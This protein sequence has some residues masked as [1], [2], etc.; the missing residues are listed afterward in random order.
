MKP[1]RK[2]IGQ[3]LERSLALHGN[4]PRNEIQSVVDRVWESLPA[5]ES[6]ELGERIEQYPSR[7][8]SRAWRLAA[9]AA[10]LI[11][12]SVSLIRSLQWNYRPP[13]HI[14]TA[15]ALPMETESEVLP[16]PPI[17]APADANVDGLLMDEVSAHISRT[18]PAPMER[19]MTLIPPY[20]DMAQSGGTQ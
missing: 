2:Q 8:K 14:E 17:H 16:L 1:T 4:P 7:A 13:P 3:I 9:V 19:I 5:Q 12:L 10:V 15:L 11:A 6:A 18:I 20:K